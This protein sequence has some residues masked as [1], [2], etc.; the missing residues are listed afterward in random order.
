MFL[1]LSSTPIVSLLTRPH[2]AEYHIVLSILSSRNSSYSPPPRGFLARI[3]QAQY[4]FVSLPSCRCRIIY[5]L[6]CSFSVRALDAGP[7]LLPGLIKSCR[8]QVFGSMV[9]WHTQNVYTLQQLYLLCHTRN[10]RT[11]VAVRIFVALYIYVSLLLH[12]HKCKYE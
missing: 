12:K 2:A 8:P 3:L 10:F 1:P 6:I 4:G 9:V 7:K 11:I 5:T